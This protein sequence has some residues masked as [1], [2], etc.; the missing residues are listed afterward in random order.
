MDVHLD[1]K[2]RVA[3]V[4]KTR[5]LMHASVAQ[6]I[7]PSI[8]HIRTLQTFNFAYISQCVL[9]KHSFRLVMVKSVKV[10]R[11]TVRLQHDCRNAERDGSIRKL[12][13]SSQ[14]L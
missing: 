14:F 9:V 2:I 7:P 5:L 4:H 13:V 8:I 1:R 6:F 10:I 3:L 12:K 11:F